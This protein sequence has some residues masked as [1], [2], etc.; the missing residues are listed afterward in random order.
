MFYRYPFHEIKLYADIFGKN[1][2]RK[3]GSNLGLGNLDHCLFLYH[4]ERRPSPVAGRAPPSSSIHVVPENGVGYPGSFLL[5]LVFP[6]PAECS[7]RVYWDLHTVLASRVPERPY[8]SFWGDVFIY[9]SIPRPLNWWNTPPARARALRLLL[10][11]VL[12]HREPSCGR[13]HRLVAGEAGG[14]GR[15]LFRL[16][17]ALSS[18]GST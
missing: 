2:S 13:C 1:A 12:F 5:L 15:S 10:L 4:A 17:Q 9:R 18:W 3:Q 8:R 7:H 6:G 14:R 11:H 16:S